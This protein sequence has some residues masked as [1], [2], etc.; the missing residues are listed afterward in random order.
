MRRRRSSAAREAGW[1]PEPGLALVRLAQGDVALAAAS[2]RDALDHP[3]NVP[4]KELPPNTDLRRAPLLAARVEIEVAAGDLVGARDAADEL[5]RVAAA[6]ESRALTASAAMA[7]GR[8]RLAA[9]DITGARHAFETAVQLWS[10]VGAPHEA[11]LARTGLAQAD[12]AARAEVGAR[13]ES[14]PTPSPVEARPIDDGQQNPNAFRQEGDYWS[15]SFQEH[16]LTLR[17]LKGLH[18]LARLLAHPGQGV[19]RAR[20]RLERGRS[21]RDHSWND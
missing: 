2:I 10:L 8:V 16:T 3:L 13:L 15:I 14:G 18:Y 7:D 12:R 6:F 5:A 4:S 21:V 9:G 11:A 20:P 17:D 1:D 19:P